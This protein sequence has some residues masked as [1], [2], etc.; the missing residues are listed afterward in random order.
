M[1]TLSSGQTIERA[2][3]NDIIRTR[4]EEILEMIDQQL[5]EAGM[6]PAAAFNLTITGGASQLTGL[7]I[8][9][10]PIG[11]SQCR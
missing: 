3:L 5:K 4:L 7:L 2:F 1:L 6:R 10:L 8:S 11:A 9:F